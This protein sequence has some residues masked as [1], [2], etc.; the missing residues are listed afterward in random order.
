MGK[1]FPCS[2][3]SK[4]VR[5][6]QKGLKCTQCRKWVHISCNGVSEKLYNDRSEM[7]SDW[8]C[9]RCTMKHMPF[10][11]EIDIQQID[12]CEKRDQVPKPPSNDHNNV[13]GIY[14]SMRR[15]TMD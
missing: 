1:Y 10:C 15:I 13:K 12:N 11:G 7:F 3:C 9:R 6:N 14:I 4:S 2:I 5:V 8:E